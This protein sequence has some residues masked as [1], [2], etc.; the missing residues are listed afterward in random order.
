[1]LIDKVNGLSESELEMKNGNRAPKRK[2]KNGTQNRKSNYNFQ[3]VF[4]Q[5]IN[6]VKER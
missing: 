3:A 5:E 4:E 2:L 1:M 6:K